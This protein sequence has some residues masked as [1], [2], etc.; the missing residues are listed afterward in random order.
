[1]SENGSQVGKRPEIM[2]GGVSTQLQEFHS[3]ICCLTQHKALVSQGEGS[4]QPEMVNLVC[5]VQGE[6]QTGRWGK[7][8]K[9]LPPLAS[10]PVHR[11]GPKEQNLTFSN[12]D[13][14]SSHSLC[15]LSC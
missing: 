11:V 13:Y 8:N 5:L 10:L 6:R 9:Q 14:I 1:M 15:V 4:W 3:G 7:M 12:S 2:D